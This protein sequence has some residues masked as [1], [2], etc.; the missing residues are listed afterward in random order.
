MKHHFLLR[1]PNCKAYL[2]RFRSPRIDFISNI[3]INHPV[4]DVF[5]FDR[6]TPFTLRMAKYYR[7][8]G[9]LIFFEPGNLKDIDKLREATQLSHI[10]K[11]TGAEREPNS[12][13][14]IVDAIDKISSFTSKTIIKT[15][16]KFGLLF[17]AERE[18]KWNYRESLK[19]NELSD[20]CG[21]GDWCTV[22]FLFFLQK[23][24]KENQISLIK[25]L[26]SSKFVDDALHFAQTIAALSCKFIGARGISNSMDKNHLLEAV[27]FYMK[28]HND[29][30][31]SV[32]KL[33]KNT[34]MNIL[35]TIN[36]DKNICPLCLLGDKKL[37]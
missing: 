7:Q 18:N 30:H 36:N 9:A 21:A 12:S 2:P 23:L 8:E 37:V 34:E 1:C 28:E 10:I 15:L 29:K 11:F 6:V 32:N 3:L 20:S 31:F 17:K 14:F 27:Y 16:G 25:T 35:E 19:I 26:Q 22:G 13:N 4:L 33:N 5:F 24:A